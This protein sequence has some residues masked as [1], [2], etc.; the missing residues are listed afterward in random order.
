MYLSG[1]TQHILKRVL[2]TTS[3]VS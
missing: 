3:T 2:L 1:F